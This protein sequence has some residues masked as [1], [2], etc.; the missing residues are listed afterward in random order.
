MSR[1]V[2]CSSCGRIHEAAYICDKKKEDPN[3]VENDRKALKL[4]EKELNSKII[5]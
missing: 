2:S 4:K 1:L 5:E 3:K